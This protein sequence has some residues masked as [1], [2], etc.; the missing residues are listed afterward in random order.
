MGSIMYR[1]DNSTA[2]TAIPAPASPGSP[3][4]FTNG[5]PLT[6]QPATIVEADWMN[7]VQEE[8]AHVIETSGLILNKLDRTQLY[9][10]ITR[11]TRLR[12]AAAADFYVSPSGSDLNPGTAG[13]PFA[14]ITYAYNFIRDRIDMNGQQCTIHLA[15]GTYGA[16]QCYFLAY[17]PPI[18]IRG[19]TSDPTQVVVHGVAAPAFD[20]ES[21]AQVALDSVTCRADDAGAV[22]S[23]DG[24]L[25]VSAN[26][27]LKNV[28][29]D[30]CSQAHIDCE[31]GGWIGP[32]GPT[33]ITTLIG[34]A[35]WHVYCVQ[36]SNMML[37]GG[38][39]N[40]NS[41]QLTLLGTPTFTN[42]FCTAN[43]AMVNFEGSAISGAAHGKKY[44]LLWNG[45]IK[46]PSP[47][48]NV[49]YL[50]GDVA[51][52]NDGSGHYGFF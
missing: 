1:I 46:I 7:S 35:A 10:A 17:G 15:N 4:F 5:N 6:G 25:V 12:L 26:V 29:F 52:T 33:G 40:P 48:T 37:Y 24:L 9:Q 22:G 45:A 51:G 16:A 36:W 42:A 30:Q 2:A 47:G 31:L 28:Y 20:I 3:G 8:I 38:A 32:A 50:P 19:N 18:I 41:K 13:Q 44:N 49:N 14:S 21:G 11:L 39:N 34:G 23:G 43:Q 27:T